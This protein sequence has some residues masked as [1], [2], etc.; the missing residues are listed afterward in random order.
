MASGIAL[1]AN[2][3]S[4][5][6]PSFI[7][8][9]FLTYKNAHTKM[10]FIDL[11][12]GEWWARPCNVLGGS[13]HPLRNLL[14]KQSGI[15]K[16]KI[17]PEEA[18][19]RLPA[20]LSLDHST[21]KNTNT[22]AKF[23]DFEYGEFWTTPAQIFSG[24]GGHPLRLKAKKKKS[25]K[26]LFLPNGSTINSYATSLGLTR[27]SNASLV[28]RKYGGEVTQ[29]WIED[30]SKQGRESSLELFFLQQFP[31]CSRFNRALGV[32][33]PKGGQYRPDF[34][35]TD[36]IYVDIDGMKWHSDLHKEK[37]YHLIK[38]K[39][40]R[41]NNILLLQFYQSEILDKESIVKSTI[42]SK[43]NKY[44][45][46]YQARKLTIREVKNQEAQEFLANNH[47]MGKFKS[48][49]HL[50]LYSDHALVSLISYKKH[51][52]GIDISRFCNKL[53]S[54]VVG[55]LSKLL[56]AIE[57]K[58]N[59]SFI[60]SFVDLRYGTGDSLLK[61]GFVLEK[62]TL[63]WKWTDGHHTFNRLKCRANMDS[64][65]LTEK[66]H[67]EELGWHRIYDAGQAK[68]IKRIR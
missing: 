39:R 21:Y 20:F 17:T 38:S 48:A 40:F 61:L 34:K 62:T 30:R 16:R 51:K 36:N 58:E 19:S 57:R 67:A 8:F 12:Y 63:G 49:K 28:F 47:L 68:F 60:Q 54:L 64:R 50:G 4:T 35:L 6:L 24:R 25:H 23:I 2:D 1:T 46:K 11:E 13:R 9:D 7:E 27:N 55:G 3:L 59:P 18:G 56:K 45:F 66:Q 22:K 14:K 5:R 43:I 32:Y 29:R 52:D 65:R 41:N 44:N 37:E 26:C 42:F 15:L 10:K 53:N 33:T 31:I